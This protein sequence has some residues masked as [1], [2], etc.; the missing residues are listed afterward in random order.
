MITMNET[1]ES[2][3]ESIEQKSKVEEQLK[4]Y[5][6][7]Q[8][9][10]YRDRMMTVSNKILEAYWHLQYII[11][12]DKYEKLEQKFEEEKKALANQITKLENKKKKAEIKSAKK[13]E[14]QEK[15]AE[16][17]DKVTNQI[18]NMKESLENK[19]TRTKS[20]LGNVKRSTTKKVEGI[21]DK[22]KDKVS[23][24]VSRAKSRLG[25]AK[26]S[27]IQRLKRTNIDLKIQSMLG[28]MAIKTLKTVNKISATKSKL[29]N[30]K[31][32]FIKRYQERKQEKIEE[33]KNERKKIEDTI[34][35]QKVE[36]ESLRAA[37]QSLN[38]APVT[39]ALKRAQVK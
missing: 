19:I 38:S 7:A 8:L 35:A 28:K 21:I 32:E 13:E 20:F 22:G 26:N 36:L 9:K 30:A 3:E 16:V 31:N 10:Y 14:R 2:L 5:H 33:R 27:A 11:H 12:V 1:I 29:G 17:K 24:K 39:P 6:T 37:K 18:S 23:G 25:V 34:A 4:N 15:L